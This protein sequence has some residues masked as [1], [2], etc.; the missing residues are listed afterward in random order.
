MTIPT[1][2]ATSRVQQHRLNDADFLLEKYQ[3]KLKLAQHYLQ[4]KEEYFTDP[5]WSGCEAVLDD[6]HEALDA[7]RMSLLCNRRRN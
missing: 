2:Q 6:V 1:N 5:V 3:H 7:I 4:G